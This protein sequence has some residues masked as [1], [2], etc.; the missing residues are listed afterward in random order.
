MLSSYENE[1]SHSNVAV[2]GGSISGVEA[3]ST[4]ALHQS[5]CKLATPKKHEDRKEQTIH[6]I[7]SRPFWTLP[8]YLPHISAEKDASFLP[9]DLVMYDLGRRPTGPIE[10]ALGPIPAEKAVK[11]NDYFKSVLGTEYEK[12]GHMH[13]A[14]A[15][16]TT[17]SQPP[18]VAIGNDYAEFVRSK[19]IEA[20]MG[21]AVS[22]QPD[23]DTGLVSVNIQTA[24]GQSKTIDKIG[25]IVLATGFT[26]FESLSFL[27]KDVLS[28][29]EF[30][31]DD[32]FLPLVLDKGGTIRSEIPDVGFVGFYR[33]PYW[34]VMEMQAR[35]L[36]ET[37]AQQ[38]MGPLVTEYQ[39]LS[40]RTLRQPHLN[41]QRGQFPMGDYVGLM[42]AFAKDLGISRVELSANDERSGPVIPARYGFSRAGTTV[43]AQPHRLVDAEMQRTLDALKATSA[44]A[45]RSFQVAAAAAIFR[46]LHGIWKFTRVESATGEFQGSGS[47]TFIPCY[48]SNSAYD[49]EYV[50]EEYVESDSTENAPSPHHSCRSI[51]RLAESG[52]E[53]VSGRITIWEKNFTSSTTDDQPDEFLCLIPAYSTQSDTEGETVEYTIVVNTSLP[54]YSN[55]STALDSI[56]MKRQYRFHFQGVSISTWER[57]D[58]GDHSACNNGADGLRYDKTHHLRTMYER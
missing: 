42:E 58:L 17:C 29:L 3:A 43:K 40:L 56:Q 4:V 12:I 18:W 44:Q 13:H 50:C 20:T 27:P 22:I 11:T 46:A 52:D 30:S 33:G 9:L 28:G 15:D 39:R 41:S 21:R 35:Y 25:V 26:P 47:V 53:S 14:S 2:I 10:Y 24:D 8:T 51:I 37:W 55:S 31:S 54:R 49:K 1:L 48:P 5:S 6:H 32:P 16:Q 57:V 45:P 34:G 36:S 38:H 23:S 19:A 7:H